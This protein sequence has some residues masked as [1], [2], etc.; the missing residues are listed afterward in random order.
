MGFSHVGTTVSLIFADL[1]VVVAWFVSYACGASIN[2]QLYI[3]IAL[4]ILMTFGF[5]S[6]VKIQQRRNTAVYQWLLRVGEAS[7]IERKGFWDLMRR[8]M[9]RKIDR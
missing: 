1:M 6:F 8:L 3:V 4:A 2:I 5:Y 7:H 9:D